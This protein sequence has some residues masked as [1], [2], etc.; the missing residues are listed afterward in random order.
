SRQSNCAS[1]ISASSRPN[2]RKWRSLGRDR[3]RWIAQRYK[4]LQ[5]RGLHALET[6]QAKNETQFAQDFERQPGAAAERAG[7]LKGFALV[8]PPALD[9]GNR[10]VEAAASEHCGPGAETCA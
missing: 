10:R 8:A 4:S 7:D 3:G 2:A 1:C 5:I 6:H 9:G